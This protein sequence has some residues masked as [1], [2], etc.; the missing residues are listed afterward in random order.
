RK[1][2]NVSGGIGLIA[3]RL[4]VEGPIKKDKSS[5]LISG[6]RTYVDV[7]TRLIN[8]GKENDPDWSP[9]PDYYFYDFNAKAT[10][11]LGPNDRLFFTGYYGRDF[12]KFYDENF[13]FNF[14]WGNTVGSLRW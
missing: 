13:N 3:S 5:F 12:F 1:E 11:D 14:N 6:R 7:F 9:I 10:F 4:T 8:E 2:Y